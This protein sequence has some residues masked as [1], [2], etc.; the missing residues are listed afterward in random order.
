[1]Q[2]GFQGASSL[3]ALADLVHRVPSYELELNPD[4]ASNAVAVDRLVSELG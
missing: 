4:P 3:A 1:V 2:S